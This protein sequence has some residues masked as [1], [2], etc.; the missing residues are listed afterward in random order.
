MGWQILVSKVNNILMFFFFNVDINFLNN[1]LFRINVHLDEDDR[2]RTRIMLM[3]EQT[4]KV[5]PKLI[6]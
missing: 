3:L 1:N 4:S 6:K 2:R 5:L